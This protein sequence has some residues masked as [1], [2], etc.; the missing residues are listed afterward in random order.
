LSSAPEHDQSA[1]RMLGERLPQLVSFDALK[2]AAGLLFSL[3]QCRSFSGE[4]MLKLRPSQYF[5][6][7]SDSGLIEAVRKGR[8]ENLKHLRGRANR[9]AAVGNRPFAACI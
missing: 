6:S 4:N 5:T 3:P 7:H 8:R 2:V 9:Q 1:N